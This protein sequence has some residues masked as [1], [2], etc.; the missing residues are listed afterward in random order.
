M[1]TIDIYNLLKNT[2]YYK[3]YHDID[4][5]S[6]ELFYKI[7]EDSIIYKLKE[8][9][10]YINILLSRGIDS[11]NLEKYVFDVIKNNNIRL[12][13]KSL[14]YVD[15]IVYNEMMNLN[16]VKM[17]TDSIKNYD[18]EYIL[19]YGYYDL[20]SYEN[21]IFIQKIYYLFP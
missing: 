18:L 16:S 1:N 8:Y 15:N 19:K 21:E 6:L 7:E 17:Y 9:L 4:K 11:E 14:S 12:F 20:V 2:Q 13:R 3:N 10:N 5:N